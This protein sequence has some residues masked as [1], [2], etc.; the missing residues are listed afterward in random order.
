[1]DVNN[2]QTK[3]PT[4]TFC[5]DVKSKTLPLCDGEN[6]T[7][8]GINGPL[9]AKI[10]VVLAEKDIQIDVEAEI[11]LKEDY[12]E[13]KRVKKDVYLTQCKLIPRSGRVVD[14]TPVSGKLFL[15]GYVRK[16]IEY[17]TACCTSKPSPYNK[18]QVVSG[19]INHTT[20]DVPFTCVTEVVYDT[21]PQINT[22]G[23]TREIDLFSDN[24]DCDCTNC[25][26]IIG[27]HQCQQ[28]F[29][30]KIVFTEKPYCE[31]EKVRIFEADL[32]KDEKYCDGAK[33]YGKLIEKM[34]LYV[35][36]KVLQIQQVNI[37]GNDC[38][39]C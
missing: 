3:K 39:S 22:R 8:Q 36:L 29:E 20:V 27:K 15:A 25:N 28:D 16:N 1:M 10:P 37:N 26:E 32:H 30:D 17:A 9:V 11:K 24:V 33:T 5:G 34:V 4:P 12:Y 23:L 35:R 31:L 6:I 2:K 21:P 18:G 13:I 14:G 38:G 19:N 7:P